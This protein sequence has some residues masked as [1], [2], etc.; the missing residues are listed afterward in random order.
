MVEGARVGT[1]FGRYQLLALLGRGGMGEVYRA[2]DTVK[3][4][5]V[6]L[7]LLPE[8]YAKTPG[9]PARFRRE[10][11]A[12]A[13]LQEPHVIPI[14]DW[15]EIDGVLYIDMRLV[16]GSDLRTLLNADGPLPPERA[17]RILAQIAAAL[18]AAHAA[19]LV[20]R[21]VKPENILITGDRDSEFAYL[22][23]FGIASDAQATQLTT[24]GSIIGTYAY[25]APERFDDG[26]VTGRSDTYSLACVLFE[27]VTGTKP[28]PASTISGLI[29]AHLTS[30]VPRASTTVRTI[31]AG[32]DAVIASGMAKD[33]AQ[34]HASAGQ[35][36]RA[37]HSALTESGPP[38]AG[39]IAETLL[40]PPYAAPV[41]EPTTIDRV[42]PD[43]E[44]QVPLPQQL[45]PPQ[46]KTSS[47][48]PV[49]ITLL[50]VGLLAVGGVVGWLAVNQG[51]AGDTASRDASGGTTA[52]AV[53]IEVTPTTTDQHAPAAPPAMTSVSVPAAP[54][55]RMPRFGDL[56]LSV[57]M[58]Q[59]SCDGTGIVVLGSAVTPGQYAEDVQSFLVEH[60]GASYL[61]TD[62]ACPSLRQ[63]T[64]DG[65]PIYAVYKAAGKTE[66]SVCTLVRSSGADAYGKW[67]DLY[68]DPTFIISCP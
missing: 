16:V 17:L 45:W 5:T 41:V 2:Y 15:G 56:G 3:G 55:Q 36:I 24:A 37:A 26:P 57:P 33:P 34:R 62:Q 10:A 46:S 25:M 59:P 1:T 64:D 63:A 38:A 28:F 47:V 23:D 11:H 8:E 67:L 40:R 53:P 49:M 39:T 14:H 51:N 52:A 9:Y 60:P 18:D 31:P 61:R 13:R 21:D 50:I 22:V 58:S 6:A 12:A 20:H 27:T 19:G 35:F 30:P 42:P 65:N 48:V 66:E 7:K 4:R 44:H 29:K 43:R 54:A 32:I 68:T